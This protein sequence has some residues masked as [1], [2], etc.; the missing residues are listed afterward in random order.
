MPTEAEWVRAARGDERRVFPW[1]DEPA[2]CE[3][4]VMTDADGEGCGRGT[5][6]KAGA[7]PE[8]VG[9]FAVHDLGGNL[10]E[11]VSDWYDPASTKSDKRRRVAKGGSWADNDPKSLSVSTRTAFV[12]TDRSNLLGFRCARSAQ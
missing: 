5:S 3:R 8:D 11:W 6:Y 12:P 2:S 7:T 10:R 4:T 9:R 1:G